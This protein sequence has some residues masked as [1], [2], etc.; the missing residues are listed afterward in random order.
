[1]KWRADKLYLMGN[2][3]KGK[4]GVLFKWFKIKHYPAYSRFIGLT[5]SD[6]GFIAYARL[7]HGKMSTDQKENFIKDYKILS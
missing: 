2:D 4:Y 1:M 3:K 5:I 6:L 7:K